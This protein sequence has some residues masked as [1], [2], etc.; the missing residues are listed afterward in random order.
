[1]RHNEAKDTWLTVMVWAC[2]CLAGKEFPMASN[3]WTTPQ[4][5]PSR[6]NLNIY[7]QETELGKTDLE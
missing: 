4:W 2:N 3:R 1:M 6:R 7:S 5:D